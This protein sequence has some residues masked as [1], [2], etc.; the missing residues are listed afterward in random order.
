MNKDFVR[1]SNYKKYQIFRLSAWKR[2]LY[3][4]NRWTCKVLK[5]IN[6]GTTCS[7]QFI[8]VLLTFDRVLAVVTP[9]K[10]RTLKQ[11]LSYPLIASGVVIIVSHVLIGGNLYFF[12]LVNGVCSQ[13]EYVSVIG[14]IVYFHYSTSFVYCGLPSALLI[15]FNAV[16]LVYMRSVKFYSKL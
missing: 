3:T 7:T 8:L 9:H 16:I 15:V 10:Y 6:Y 12:D 11:N 13:G 14:G 4:I 1:S 5:W 2:D